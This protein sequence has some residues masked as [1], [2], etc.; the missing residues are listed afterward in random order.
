M[1]FFFR[2]IKTA[3]FLVL[4]LGGIS[5]HS[6]TALDSEL[7]AALS[8]PSD[9]EALHAL[10]GL[11][12]RY[13]DRFSI[14]Y[15]ISVRYLQM[16]AVSLAEPFLVR[17]EALHRQTHD[18]EKKATILGGL[19]IAAYQRADYEKTVEWGKRALALDTESGKVFG[20]ITARGLLAEGRVEEAL[21]FFDAAWKDARTGMSAEDYRSYARALAS[22]GRQADALEVLALYETAKPYEPGIGLVE[23]SL[24]ESLGAF[25]DAV[26]AAAKEAEYARAFGALDQKA[27]AGNL[28]TLD[29]KLR[30]RSF[31]PKGEGIGDLAVVQDYFSGKWS[32]IP[33]AG[34]WKAASNNPF[35]RFIALSA[36]I[37]RGAAEEGD[38][39]SYIALLPTFKNLPSY[40]Y[41]LSLVRAAAAQGGEDAILSLERAIDLAP[42]APASAL[43]RR[44]LAVR[45]GLDAADGKVLLTRN[46]I[47]A[48][49]ERA[50]SS[51]APESLSRLVEMLPLRDCAQ[52]LLAVGVLRSFAADS[53]F[54][55]YLL[56]RRSASKGRER[57][58]LDYILSN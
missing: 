31:N 6:D 3:V 46:E 52:T 15:E 11:D 18:K 27:L 43:Y 40:F 8:K 33:A 5:C 14:K 12:Q 45:L 37:E 23:S 35:A 9:A 56:E 58:R 49:A 30:D 17:A 16:G 29:A 55:Q 57:E 48:A 44:A 2:S 25:S 1:R 24:Y 54:R 19:A 36:A 47:A 50:G 34:S 20:F 42:G 28:A 39:D 10:L 51:R 53:A 38:A 21:P 22:A 32:A 26:L 41:R 13:P 4:A 7:A